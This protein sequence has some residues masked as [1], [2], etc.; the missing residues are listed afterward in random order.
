MYKVSIHPPGTTFPPNGLPTVTLHW[1]NDDGGPGFDKDSRLVFDPPA[2][3]TYQVRI[4]DTR[5]QGSLDHGYRLTIRPPRPDFEVNFRVAN[6]VSKG[7]A[8]PVRVN[9]KR[10]DEFDGVIDLKLLDVP[11]GWHA[12]VTNIAPL[13][14][15][16]AFALY[17][18][19]SATVPAKPGPMVVEARAMIH[20]KEVVRRATGTW[21]KV[22]EPGD[23]VTT[24]EQSE[25]T[26]QPGGETR[27]TVNIERRN[28][29][30]GRIP[31]EVEGLP[32]GVR[33]LDVGLNGIL[34]TEME[35]R[36]TFV[37]YAEPWVQA[38]NHPIV[39]Q[40]KREGKGTD[41]GA[42]SVLLRVTK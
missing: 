34:I 12:P 30:A 31:I 22:I 6:A 37:L 14:N 5:G 10:S 1:R 3:G 38:M 8:V 41:H 16:T 15:S 33:V 11:T 35:K 17:A 20:G 21:P 18:E 28:K 24:T 4:G 19:A 2:D 9:V 23:I 13:D 36:R 7:G 29:F 25:V 39:V 42:K 26:L 27:I 40:T 32:H